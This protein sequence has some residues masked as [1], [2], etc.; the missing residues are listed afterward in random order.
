[1]HRTG[2]RAIEQLTDAAVGFHKGSH[3]RWGL[4][5][6]VANRFRPRNN[7]K[8]KICIEVFSQC[9]SWPPRRAATFAPLYVGEKRQKNKAKSVRPRKS[10]SAFFKAEKIK[11]KS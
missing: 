11:L 8:C 10:F 5:E 7:N 4:G 9:P 3:G 6:T 2:L 1:M